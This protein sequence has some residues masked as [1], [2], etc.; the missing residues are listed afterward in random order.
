MY[1]PRLQLSSAA[2]G[3]RSQVL[4]VEEAIKNSMAGE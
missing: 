1:L 2:I 4:N 3:L